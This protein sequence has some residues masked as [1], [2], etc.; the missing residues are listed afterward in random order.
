MGNEIEDY[1]YELEI[2]LADQEKDK[3][4]FIDP[5]YEIIDEIEELGNALMS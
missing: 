1:I 5:A 4:L 3:Y 2:A